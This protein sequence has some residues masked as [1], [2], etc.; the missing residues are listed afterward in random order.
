[1]IRF[2]LPPMKTTQVGLF[3]VVGSLVC[4]IRLEA[5]ALVPTSINDDYLAVLRSGDVPKLRD[6][7]DHGAS[8][9]ARD[10]AG[11]PPLMHAAVDGGGACLPLLLKRGPARRAG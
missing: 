7:L 3:F 8:P 11:S 6:A 2:H 4:L 10:A 1:M 9:N 5:G